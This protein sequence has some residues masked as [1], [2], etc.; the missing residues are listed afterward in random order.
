MPKSNNKKKYLASRR[1]RTGD[2]RQKNEYLTTPFTMLS[3]EIKL[4]QIT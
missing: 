4:T 3:L 1:D 2:P